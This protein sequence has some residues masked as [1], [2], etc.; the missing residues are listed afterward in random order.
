MKYDQTWKAL[1]VIVLFDAT[2]DTARGNEWKD[3]CG[4]G[5]NAD[6]SMLKLLT[7]SV[8]LIASLSISVGPSVH[9][10]HVPR[11]LVLMS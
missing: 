4:E 3:L 8:L 6:L 7:T 9:L 11:L 1:P 2:S 10:H 5:T